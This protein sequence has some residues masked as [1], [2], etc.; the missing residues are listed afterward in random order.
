MKS[1]NL[2][3]DNSPKNC[4]KTGVTSHPLLQSATP[5]SH[6][7]ATAS[8]LP[9]GVM[10]A[11]H[12]FPGG[13]VRKH[14]GVKNLEVELPVPKTREHQWVSVEVK[15]TFLRPESGPRPSSWSQSHRQGSGSRSQTSVQA[16]AVH[17]QAPGQLSAGWGCG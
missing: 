3:L 6:G 11:V 2:M 17:A 16:T 8:A 13:Q 5:V 4:P 1:W 12:S 15:S 14:F 10:E 7:P 9:M